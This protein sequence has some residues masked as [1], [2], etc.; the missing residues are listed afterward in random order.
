MYYLHHLMHAHNNLHQASD[1]TVS[2]L[3]QQLVQMKNNGQ[4]EELNNANA[5]I[6]KLRKLLER[7]RREREHFSTARAALLDKLGDEKDDA[8]TRTAWH[9]QVDGGGPLDNTSNI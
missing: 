9:V 3:E 4:A 5:T 2:R 6:S 7:E 8:L 1:K